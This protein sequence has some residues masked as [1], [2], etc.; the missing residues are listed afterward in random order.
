MYPICMIWPNAS[1]KHELGT[2]W[3]RAD[4]SWRLQY[5]N[6]KEYVEFHVAIGDSKLIKYLHTGT[7]QVSFR[8]II[9]RV[10]VV[11]VLLIINK[12][13]SGN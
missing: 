13:T 3:P 12:V 9:F 4:V 10:G 7:F 5:A 1:S 6:K 8:P 2:N 11:I